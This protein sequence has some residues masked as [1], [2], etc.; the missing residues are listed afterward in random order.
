MIRCKVVAAVSEATRHGILRAGPSVTPDHSP[1]GRFAC[2]S[3]RRE[4]RARPGAP[5]CGF[6]PRARR[7]RQ[8]RGCRERYTRAATSVTADRSPRSGAF[9]RRAV[10]RQRAAPAGRRRNTGE[11]RLRRGINS[12]P[13]SS[14]TTS[15]PPPRAARPFHAHCNRRSFTATSRSRPGIAIWA[16]PSGAFTSV[17]CT[18]APLQCP[19]P[20][21]GSGHALGPSG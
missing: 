11:E 17:E 18:G 16:T 9:R 1:T 21:R 6:R 20:R 19:R 10:R 8:S 2:P 12:R 14:S 4:R 7:R 13:R 3:S 15:S 5:E